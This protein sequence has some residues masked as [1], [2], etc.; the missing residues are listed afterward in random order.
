M[1]SVYIGLGTNIEDRL[2]NLGTA[3]TTI[4]RSMKISNHS[5]IYETPPW[6][7]TD[8]PNFLNMVIEVNTDTP[9]QSL[10]DHLKQ[11]EKQLGRQ[12][13]F[14][15]GPRV[16]DLDILFYGKEIIETKQLQIPHPK[17]QERAFVLVPL[18]EI[19]QDFVHPVLNKTIYELMKVIDHSGITR[20]L[21]ANSLSYSS[22]D[23]IK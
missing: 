14:R 21:D 13:T 5:S 23:F 9:P 15:Y 19:A 2:L 4:S 11:I 7:Y 10:L 8:Q 22:K 1:I 16:I 6:G 12:K 17:I 3:L 20:I 18:N